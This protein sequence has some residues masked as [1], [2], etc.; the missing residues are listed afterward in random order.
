MEERKEKDPRIILE[1]LNRQAQQIQ[2]TILALQN[3]LKLNEQEM[4]R[5]I[6]AMR[7]LRDMFPAQTEGVLPNAKEDSKED[8]KDEA[9]LKPIDFINTTVTEEKK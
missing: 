9:E 8:P 6:G 3:D 4:Q 1:R 7:M 2:G 5:T